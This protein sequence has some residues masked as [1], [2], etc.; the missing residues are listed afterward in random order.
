MS[1]V[2]FPKIASEGYCCV[3]GYLRLCHARGESRKAMC[4]NLSLKP[5][6]L[7]HNYQKL[8]QGDHA[9]M[10]HADCLEPIINEL[11]DEKKGEA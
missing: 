7:A 3:S 9:C 4:E 6:T 8:A 2:L 11:L 5:W 10:R 1:R